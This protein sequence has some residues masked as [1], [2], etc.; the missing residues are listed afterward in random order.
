MALPCGRRRLATHWG[1]LLL[2]LLFSNVVVSE[3]TGQSLY[4]D[5]VLFWFG[6]TVI[7]IRP[8]ATIVIELW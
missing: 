2:L 1:S 8:D 7:Y 5:R 6:T 3:V 4:Y